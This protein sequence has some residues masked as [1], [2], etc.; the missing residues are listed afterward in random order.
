MLC[1]TLKE[2]NSTM[3]RIK[4]DHTND[5]VLDTICMIPGSSRM[6]QYLVVGLNYVRIRLPKSWL[7]S[8]YFSS[9]LL[10]VL[11]INFSPW[12]HFLWCNALWLV[13]SQHC[14]I[15]VAFFSKNQTNKNKTRLMFD[16]FC[17]SFKIMPNSSLVFQA[18]HKLLFI[19]FT[20]PLNT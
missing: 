5:Q 13:F 3:Q 12:R 11:T 18:F 2:H 7:Q 14:F 9:Q 6:L 8:Q 4:Y 16:Y 17:V 10:L 20:V 1:F 15:Y 19:N